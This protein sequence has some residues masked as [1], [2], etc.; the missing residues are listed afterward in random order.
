VRTVSVAKDLMIEHKLHFSE[1]AYSVVRR[2]MA[3]YDSDLAEII[4][5]SLCL[6][7][8]VLDI[9]LINGELIARKGDKETIINVK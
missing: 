1:Q 5:K 9:S 6:A 8:L 7:D 4:G 3:H 2:L